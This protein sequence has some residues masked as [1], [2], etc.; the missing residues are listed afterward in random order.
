MAIIVGVASW[1]FGI[2]ATIYTYA[3]MGI[4]SGETDA[5]ALSNSFKDPV[6][7]LLNIISS[8][9]QFMLNIISLVAGAL[10][11]FNLNERKNF[12]GTFERIQN[13]GNT[14]EN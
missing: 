14:P 8:I 11:Y 9:A 2:P 1:A 6:Y 3:K 4:L 7:I 10:V 12:T 5:E 13:L